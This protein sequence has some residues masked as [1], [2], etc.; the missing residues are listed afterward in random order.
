MKNKTLLIEMIYRL[1]QME[2]DTSFGKD[3]DDVHEVIF[4]ERNK[5]QIEKIFRKW[6]S[7]KQP[8]IFGRLASKKNKRP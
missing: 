5:N 8:C 4:T 3:I 2:K 6:A 1:P 7:V